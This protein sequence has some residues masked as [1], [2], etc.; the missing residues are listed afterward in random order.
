MQQSK[1]MGKPSRNPFW[2]YCTLALCT[3][4]H[5]GIKADQGDWIVGFTNAA[6]GNK[7]V[8]AMKVLERIHFN[9][10]F[11]DPRFQRKKPLMTGTWRQRCG[12][13]IYWQDGDDWCQLDSPYRAWLRENLA[14]GRKVR[15]VIIAKTISPDLKLAASEIQDIDVFEYE[16]K[17]DLKKI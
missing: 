17:L 9:N 2:G 11:T 3:P 6:R 16:L 10:Y 13:N 14:D 8:F 12:D 15:G 4:N 7:L 5:M 1:T